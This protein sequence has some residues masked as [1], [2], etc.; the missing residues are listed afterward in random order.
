ML[1]RSEDDT[2]G[3]VGKCEGVDHGPR[4][5]EDAGRAGEPERRDRAPVDGLAVEGEWRWMG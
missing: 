1:C 2:C 3:G 4:P 5:D